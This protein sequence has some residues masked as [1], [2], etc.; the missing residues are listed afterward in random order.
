MVLGFFESKTA[1][2]EASLKH[3]PHDPDL[4]KKII[5][6]SLDKIAQVAIDYKEG[7]KYILKLEENLTVLLKDEEVIYE[8]TIERFIGIYSKL[9]KREKINEM[10]G[11]VGMILKNEIEKKD[12]NK[13]DWKRVEWYINLCDRNNLYP[14]I[15]PEEIPHPGK[16]ELKEIKGQVLPTS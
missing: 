11:Y 7:K 10:A 5:D 1:N 9:E 8:D 12:K 14:L 16:R 6:S 15:Q 3:N 2:L 4:R 13:V